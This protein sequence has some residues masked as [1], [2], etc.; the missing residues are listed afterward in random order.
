MLES[1]IR[2]LEMQI[3]MLQNQI[4]AI[5][6]RKKSKSKRSDKSRSRRTSK[7]PVVVSDVPQYVAPPPQPKPA[8]APPQP[9]PPK[10][11][12]QPRQPA[13][14]KEPVLREISFEEK[15]EL[16][17]EINRLSGEKLARVVQIIHE[18]MPQLSNASGQEEIELDIDSLDL[19]T[20]NRLWKSVM[21][22]KRRRPPGTNPTEAADRIAT[23]ERELAMMD[24]RVDKAKKAENMGFDH[25]TSTED[26]DESASDDSESE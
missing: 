21:G 26:S 2:I 25:G 13:K 20:L 19:L 23:L 16:S 22:K 14:K 15:K 5:K 7:T 11:P 1:Q 18:S 24:G 4:L 12:K 8:P 9:K 10:P 6:Q 3:A 17:E